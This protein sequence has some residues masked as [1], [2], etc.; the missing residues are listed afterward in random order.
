MLLRPQTVAMLAAI[1]EVLEESNLT[2]TPAA[3]FAALMNFADT[4][5]L[6][7]ADENVLAALFRLLG[8]VVPRYGT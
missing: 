1:E 8:L 7:T 4:T 2:P 6:D 5:P 3:Y